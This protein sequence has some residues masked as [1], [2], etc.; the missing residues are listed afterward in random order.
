MTHFQ[1]HSLKSIIARAALLAIAAAAPAAA[2]AQSSVDIYGRMDLGASS[3][4]LVDIAAGTRA[5]ASSLAGAQDFSTGS[6]LG[7]RGTEDLGGGLRAGFVY[8]IGINADRTDGGNAQTRLANLSLQSDTLGTLRIGTQ[9]TPLSDLRELLPVLPNLPGAREPGAWFGRHIDNAISYTSPEIGH[10]RFS[11]LGIDEPA[12]QA[13]ML[14]ATFQRE[15]L[16][17]HAAFGQGQSETA[18]IDSVETQTLSIGVRYFVSPLLE[19]AAIAEFSEQAGQRGS[20][21]HFTRDANVWVLS[22]RTHV[23]NF[24]PFIALAGGSTQRT[25][26]AARLDSESTAW[27]IGTTYNLSTRTHLYAAASEQRTDGFGASRGSGVAAGI[28]HTF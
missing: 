8:E 9:Y 5:S 24:A 22:A 3:V 23:G 10:W 18:H 14:A 11:A 1:Q 20:G 4:E 27:Q 7:F 25:E 13:G 21:Q 19:L 26:G 16:E 6:R 17:F 12:S 15:A 28:V 2:L